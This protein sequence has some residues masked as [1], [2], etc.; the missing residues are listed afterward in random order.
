MTLTYTVAGPPAASISTPASGGTYTIGQTVATSF[1]CT[2][3]TDGPG[4]KSCVDSNGASGTGTLDTSTAGTHTYTVTATSQDGQTAS[5]SITY[6]VAAASTPPTSA[7]PTTITKV[8]LSK[9]VL[10]WCWGHG[11][12]YPRTRLRFHLNRAATVRL[13]LLANVHGRWR[14]VA[15]AAR[16]DPSRQQQRPAART[17]AQ[18]ADPG[19]SRTTAR[20]A[21]ARR[22]LDGQAD[23]TSDR[24]P[25]TSPRLT[26]SKHSASQA[27]VAAGGAA[28]PQLI[29]T[30]ENPGRIRSVE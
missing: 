17:L 24:P 16:H 1:A 20:R 18:P 27:V 28:S 12:V 9:P 11:C 29:G 25:S 6:T 23:A 4:I 13:V 15:V 21:Q 2:E 26:D 5:A 7:S 30:H 3:G 8:S 19:T 22:P 10:I 14:S